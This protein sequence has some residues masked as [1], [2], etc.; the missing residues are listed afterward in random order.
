MK[1]TQY[2]KNFFY[3]LRENF[4]SLFFLS[5]AEP[6]EIND[7]SRAQLL[8]NMTGALMSTPAELALVSMATDRQQPPRFRKYYSGG[9]NSMLRTLQNGGLTASFRGAVTTIART[10]LA[11]I[12]N[13]VIYNK[14][15]NLIRENDNPF[16]IY[17]FL[18]YDLQ[19]KAF[20]TDKGLLKNEASKIVSGLVLSSIVTSLVTLPVDVLK[21]RCVFSIRLFFLAKCFA[22]KISVPLKYCCLLPM[23]H[24]PISLF[25]F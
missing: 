5:H 25:R 14:V 7:Q 13:F 2:R 22:P 4:K 18:F 3:L 17:I 16:R 20:L 1:I 6:Q 21:T 8:A 15:Q 23:S 11:S 9:Y 24:R 12:C 19:V 10:G